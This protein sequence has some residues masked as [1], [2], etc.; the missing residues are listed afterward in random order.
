MRIDL[1]SIE[2]NF[3]KAESVLDSLPSGLDPLMLEA[4]VPLPEL[5]QFYDEAA[6]VLA[7]YQGCIC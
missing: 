6:F 1:S 7:L 2:P 5:I 4:Y 3:T